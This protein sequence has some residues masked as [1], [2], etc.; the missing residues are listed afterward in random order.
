MQ[1]PGQTLTVGVTKQDLGSQA[2]ILSL[3]GTNLSVILNSNSATPTTAAQ[4]VNAIQ[5]TPNIASVVRAR[6]NG[7]F[8]DAKLG[9][10]AP[11]SFGP[12]SINR[13]NDI[14][15]QPGSALVGNAPSDNEVTLRFAESLPDDFYRIEVFGFDDPA[16]GI[17]GLKNVATL[18]MP[19]QFFQPSV[20]GTRQETV[21]F[22]LD[23]GARV[24]GVVP[25]PVVRNADDSISQLRDT[26]VVY[27]DN[28]KLL[29]ENDPATGKPTVRSAENPDF[30]KLIYTA[31]TIRSENIGDPRD[32]NGNAD[33]KEFLPTSVSYNASNNTATLKFSSDIDLLRPTLTSPRS[34]YRLRI[35]TRESIP[36]EPTRR[37]VAELGNTF[38]TADNLGTIGTSSTSLTSLILSSEIRTTTL[39]LDRLGASNDPGHRDLGNTGFENHINELFGA[40]SNP[41]ITNI[42]YNFKSAYAP[43]FVNSITELQKERI[44]EGLQIWS[45]YLGVQF[46]ESADQGFTFATGSLTAL[47][48][49]PGVQFENA[50]NF[51]ARIDPVAPFNNSLLVMNVARQWNGNFGEDYFKISMTAI[52]MLLGL[53][54]AGDLPDSTLLSL[55]TNY[56][57]AAPNSTAANVINFE[58]IFPGAQDILHGQFVHR[59]TVAISICI[60]SRS[61][62]GTAVLSEASLLLKPSPNEIVL[63]AI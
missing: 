53:E 37:T 20:A 23:L 36:F 34:A 32:T 9:T 49:G 46:T 21:E 22:R 3:A 26:I 47:T 7:G 57:N 52:G 10:L 16:T 54:H 6:I 63:S 42:F 28:D 45:N 55:N 60:V 56:L 19:A 17:V 18:G 58:P 38:T 1:N 11:N 48:P 15:V 12:I 30:Y 43:G 24:T 51:S 50:L 39:G 25:Q 41:G 8:A 61:T 4:L 2:P 59:P 29:V 13:T 31:D 33:D 35:G 62:S 14:I 5:S 27:F 40:D 44:R